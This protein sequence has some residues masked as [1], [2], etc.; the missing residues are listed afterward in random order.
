[1]T[2]LN[3]SSPLL[4]PDEA[5]AWLRSSERTLERWRSEGTGP[6]FVRLGRRVAYRL[7]D[8][9]TWVAQQAQQRTAAAA[10]AQRTV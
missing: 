2:V 10:G 6:L 3:T 4:T 5:A 7:N 1:M 8:L 9:E